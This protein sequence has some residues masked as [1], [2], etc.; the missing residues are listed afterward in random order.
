MRKSNKM[1]ALM[2]KASGVVEFHLH[3]FVWMTAMYLYRY[4]YERVGRAC[5]D[6]LANGVSCGGA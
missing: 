5:L 1:S 4:F 2:L 6:Q 3:H